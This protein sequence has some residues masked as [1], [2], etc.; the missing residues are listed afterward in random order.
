MALRL[1]VAPQLR[2]VATDE[3]APASDHAGLRAAVFARIEQR[4]FISVLN[5]ESDDAVDVLMG[6]F[7]QLRETFRTHPEHLKGDHHL[8][9]FHTTTLDKSL[10]LDYNSVCYYM[11]EFMCIKATYFEK[12]TAEE[13]TKWNAWEDS[14]SAYTHA[15]AVGAT[16]RWWTLWTRRYRNAERWSR[17]CTR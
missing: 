11:L 16:N 17:T 4:G 7:K 12:C 8:E 2:A 10:Y 1:S 13:F 14:N 15:M 5:Q 3:P 6:H 9:E